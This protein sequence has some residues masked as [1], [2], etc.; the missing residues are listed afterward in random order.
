MD[1]PVVEV[2]ANEGGEAVFFE[3]CEIDFVEQQVFVDDLGG[4]IICASLEGLNGLMII[5]V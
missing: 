4:G 1:F 3:F 2:I 5:C